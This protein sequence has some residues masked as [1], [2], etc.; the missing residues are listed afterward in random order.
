MKKVLKITGIAL[1]VIIAIL[2]AIPI[3][4]KGK[5]IKIVKSE[6]N[7]NINAKVDFADIDISLIRRFPRVSVAIKQ[8]QVIGNGRF[9]SDTLIAANSID[10]ALNLMSIIKGDKM[11]I[12]SVAVNQ[13]RI[14][15]IVAKDGAVN[16]DIAKPDTTTTSDKENASFNVVSNNRSPETSFIT[17]SNS[18]RSSSPSFVSVIPLG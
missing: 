18:A 13:P 1:L 5:I 15:A 2:F 6:I 9:S 4:F 17:S 8:I 7:K 11:T 10:A 16:W 14:H 12:Y 3:L